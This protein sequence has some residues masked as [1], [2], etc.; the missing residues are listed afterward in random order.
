MLAWLAGACAKPATT[1]APGPVRDTVYVTKVDTVRLEAPRDTV[2]ERLAGRLQME[3]LER[4][5]EVADLRQKLDEAVREVVKTM[6]RLQTAPTRAE[7]ASATAEAEVAYQALRNRPGTGIVALEAKRLLDQSSGEFARSNYAGA[8]YLANQAKNVARSAASIGTVADGS[9]VAG[10][11]PFATPISLT[12][13]SR[14]NVR[15]GPGTRYPVRLTLDRGAVIRGVSYAGDWIRV[16]N[17]DGT[18]GWILGAL[19][20]GQS[21]AGE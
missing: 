8:I 3:L 19:L 12:A 20:E 16:A 21:R 1:V 14:A 2:H 18:G 15:E 7:A 5:A 17:P 11:V 6:A 10:E 4:E 13:T 9:P